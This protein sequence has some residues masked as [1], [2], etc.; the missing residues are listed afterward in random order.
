MTTILASYCHLYLLVLFSLNKY[1]N[2][3][4]FGKDYF[5]LKQTK[6]LLITSKELNNCDFCN[7]H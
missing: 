6:G 7:T 2:Y 4:L 1:E 5:T 3:A